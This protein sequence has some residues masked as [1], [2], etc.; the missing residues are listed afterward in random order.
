MTGEYRVGDWALVSSQD[1][2][3]KLVKVTRLG[4]SSVYVGETRYRL[5]DGLELGEGRAIIS[6]YIS[7]LTLEQSR[8]IRKEMRR[9]YLI[10]NI[11][12][13]CDAYSLK[14]LTSDK[15]EQIYAIL[16]NM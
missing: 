15:L 5:N 16:G 11:R 12:T 13:Q 7:P 6:R 1:G 10:T 2:Y 9:E 4:P 14:H 3:R 8:E